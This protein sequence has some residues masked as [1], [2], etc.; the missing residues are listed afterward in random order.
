MRWRKCAYH[1]FLRGAGDRLGPFCPEG[2]ELC[3][4]AWEPVDGSS[5]ISLAEVEGDGGQAVPDVTSSL[6]SALVFGDG[7]IHRGAQDD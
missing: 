6:C 7:L 5:W 3:P 1:K 2:T 4:G